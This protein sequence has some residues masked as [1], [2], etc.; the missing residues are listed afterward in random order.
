[1]FLVPRSNDFLNTEH[2]TETIANLNTL[3]TDYY[4]VK[5]VEV[6][7]SQ[8]PSIGHQNPATLRHKRFQTS[9]ETPGMIMMMADVKKNHNAAQTLYVL[10]RCN[11]NEKEL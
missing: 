6:G 11:E 3:P 7:R 5:F 8:V 4:L 1:M 9:I 10:A 2:L